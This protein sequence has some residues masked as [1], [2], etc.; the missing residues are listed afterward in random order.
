MPRSSSSRAQKLFSG[1][2]GP[3][4]S[5]MEVNKCNM[6]SRK[7]EIFICHSPSLEVQNGIA[8]DL[9]LLLQK[10]NISTLCSRDC[11]IPIEEVHMIPI[12][13][14]VRPSE[15]RRTEKGIFRPAFVGA[16]KYTQKE[17]WKFFLQKTGYLSGWKFSDFRWN[18]C[19]LLKAVVQD[20]IKMVNA[21]VLEVVKH[22][23]G[24]AEK[25]EK[26]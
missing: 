18:S 4:T 8:K 20:V 5:T 2:F 22:P 6:D 15:V 24:L 25:T 16:A 14:D 11:S 19:K 3:D 21:N 1:C 9:L 12:F 10:L 17:E 23:V 26:L 13:Y 7:C